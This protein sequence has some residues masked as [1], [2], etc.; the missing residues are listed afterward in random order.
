MGC[1][2]SAVAKVTLEE[3]DAGPVERPSADSFRLTVRPGEIASCSI[4]LAPR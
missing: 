2:I 3:L 4:T 1:P